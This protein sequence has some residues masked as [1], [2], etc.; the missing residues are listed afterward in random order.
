MS[1]GVSRR[2]VS[3]VSKFAPIVGNEGDIPHANRQHRG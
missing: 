3:R 2:L 1:P